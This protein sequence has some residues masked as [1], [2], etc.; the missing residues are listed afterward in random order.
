MCIDEE[1]RRK[2]KVVDIAQRITKLKCRIGRP[3]GKKKIIERR[4]RMGKCSVGRPP[5]WTDDLVK[6]A[7]SHCMQVASDPSRWRSIGEAY[8]QQWTATG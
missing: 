3:M 7:G 8:V 4:P 5:R 2:T 1:I 6:T